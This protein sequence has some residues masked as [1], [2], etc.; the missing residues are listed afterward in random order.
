MTGYECGRIQIQVYFQFGH[1]FMF[2]FSLS[3]S[4]L[5]LKNEIMLL[6][7]QKTFTSYNAMAHRLKNPL[8]SLFCFK[9]KEAT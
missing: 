4:Y 9:N 1:A 3:D 2:L 5:F 8:I 6:E 7:I